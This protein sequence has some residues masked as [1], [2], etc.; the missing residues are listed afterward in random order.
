[1]E[2]PSMLW[3]TRPV[4]S[5]TEQ[6]SF[7]K[8]AEMGEERRGVGTQSQKNNPTLTLGFSPLEKILPLKGSPVGPHQ[9][10]FT[11]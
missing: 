5:D 9:A 7:D 3:R 6:K 11:Y 1:M 8:S 2:R 10:P 4:T